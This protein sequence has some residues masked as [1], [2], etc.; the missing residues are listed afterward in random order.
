[1]NPPRVSVVLP[2]RDR[3]PILC[4]A[5][6]SVLNQSFGDL[7]LIVVDDGST[8]NTASVLASFDDPRLVYLRLG[9]H[10]GAA[11]ARN[12]GIRQARGSYV[13]FQDSDDEWLPD[14]LA[15]Q[16][17][18]LEAPGSRLAGVGGRYSIDA[19]PFSGQIDAPRLERGQDYEADL[20]EGPC[21]ITPLWV[22][23]RE[24]LDEL[25]L[26]DERMPCLEDWDLMLRL[27][28]LAPIRA[29]ADNVLI[30][31]GAADSLGADIE[32]RAPAMEALLQRHGRRF[33]AYPHRH[34]SY[35]LELAYL[36][37]AR[38]QRL[39]A[40]RYTARS[41]RRRGATPRMLRAFLLAC[42]RARGSRRPPWPIPG[43][44]ADTE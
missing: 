31:R 39:R 33:L 6:E 28:N 42:A 10:S 5:I 14:K 29:V 13:A 16:L 21:C 30:K 37:L 18:L 15:R 9:D 3:A 1:M 20:L 11:A 40:L 8:D 17:E 44:A 2:T 41:L 34:A 19:G 38:R 7:E 24:I 43:L 36:C 27:S 26:F 22:I 12:A 25:E 23:R 32:R 35:C 4:R